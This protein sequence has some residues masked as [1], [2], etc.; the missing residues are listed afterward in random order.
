MKRKVA[1][2]MATLMAGSSLSGSYVSAASIE[3]RSEENV[4]SEETASENEDGGAS[5]LAESEIPLENETSQEEE[6]I[7]QAEDQEEDIEFLPEES[8]VLDEELYAEEEQ[9]IEAE[10]VPMLME[11]G[12][13]DTSDETKAQ[14]SIELNSATDRLYYGERGNGPLTITADTEGLDE[15]EEYE[16]NWDVKQ[17]KNEQEEAVSCA[18]VSA[19]GTECTITVDNSL[20]S[21]EYFDLKIKVTVKKDD[22]YVAADEMDIAV[23]PTELEL[24][25]L[26]QDDTILAGWDY[27]IDRDYTIWRKDASYPDGEDVSVRITQVRVAEDKNELFSYDH[28]DEQPNIVIA[29]EDGYYHLNTSRRPEELRYG[30]AVIEFDYAEPAGMED[31]EHAGDYVSGMGRFRLCVED[32]KYSAWKIMQRD[33]A[34][35]IPCLNEC[36]YRKSLW[37]VK[38]VLPRSE[39]NDSRPILCKFNYGLKGFHCVMGGKIDNAYDAVAAIEKE[40]GL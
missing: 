26:P 34:R 21:E 17:Y 10:P 33:A 1:L 36:T 37:E 2:L 5:E 4:Q 29:D 24:G 28:E 30:E 14:Y 20:E 8:V 35:Y 13:E 38:T 19:E 9:F 25:G 18:E 7:Q 31:T 15:S 32:E 16:I 22:E 12:E 11:D 3:G 6:E 39:V 40:L 27:T 23:V